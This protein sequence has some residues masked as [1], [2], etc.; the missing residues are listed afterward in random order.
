VTEVNGATGVPA[1]KRPERRWLAGLLSGVIVLG[2]AGAIR[3][4]QRAAPKVEPSI[5]ETPTMD[6]NVIVVTRDFVERFGLKTAVAREG[7]LHPV[8]KVAG[9]VDFD[10]RY[11]AAV[12]TRL[13][14]LVRSV[15]HFEGDT[16]K[17]GE[18]LATI[19]SAELGAAQ[20]SIVS[21]RAAEKAARLNLAREEELGARGLTTTRETELASANFEGY[22]SKLLAAQQQVSALGGSLPAQSGTP[23]L[24]VQALRAPLAGT[25]VERRINPGQSVEAYLSAFRI[26]DLDHLWIE[27]AVFERNLAN[28]HRGDR[29]ELLP[30]ANPSEPIAGEIAHL[31]EQVDADTRTAI[32]RVE[33]DN[34]KRRLRPGQAVTA[35]IRRGVA[36]EKAALVPQAAVTYVDGKPTVFVAESELRMVVTPVELGEDDGEERE[37]EA[38]VSAG[39]SVLVEGVFDL[40]SE[41]FR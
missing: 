17:R 27:L 33:V 23:V 40:K 35:R 19:D 13:K 14:G 29:V 4:R 36:G 2:V 28:L 9:T 38:G 34:R 16:V 11:V 20:A 25:V 6:G 41:L 30:L 10:P 8:I 7:V 24:G 18:L 31:G 3:I 32:V 26:A 5:A 15:A 39:Q 37:I 1:A 21:L 22:R 12:G